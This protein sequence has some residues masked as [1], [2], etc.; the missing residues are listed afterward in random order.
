MSPSDWFALLA[1]FVGLPGAAVASATLYKS[2]K[3]RR[4]KAH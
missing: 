3:R 4:R 2:I 1:L